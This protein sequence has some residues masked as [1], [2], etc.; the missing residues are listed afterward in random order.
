MRIFSDIRIEGGLLGPDILDQIIAGELPGQRPNDFGLPKGR[1]LTD[2][3]AKILR[4]YAKK[5]WGVFKD[6]LNRLPDS[7]TATPYTRFL[8]YSFS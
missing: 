6:R 5:L 2:E 4:E 8:G 3:I 1:T 7:D